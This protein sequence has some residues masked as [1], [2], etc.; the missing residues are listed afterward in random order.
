MLSIH[1]LRVRFDSHYVLKDVSLQVAPGEILALI[2]PNGAGKSTLIRA[3]SGVIDIDSGSVSFNQQDLGDLG[4]GDRARIL[5]VVPQ[6]RPLGGAF[7]VEQTVLLGRTAHMNFLGRASSEDQEIARW[8]MAKTS[9]EHLAQRRNA[10]LSGGEQ[11]RVLL[12]RALTQQTPVLLLDEPTNHLDLE[13][14]IKFLQLIQDLIAQENLA[15][16]IAL[17]DLNQVSLYADRVALLVAGELFAQ[18]T[19]AEVLTEENLFAAYNTRVQIIRDRD[20]EPPVI[21]PK[22]RNP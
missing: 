19:P 5:G 18:G 11:Q 20:G 9:I 3:V 8:A 13:H 10:E 17:H 6:A 22:L 14:Q 7:S 16:L 1:S 15:V 2:G 21:L 12:A 4:N